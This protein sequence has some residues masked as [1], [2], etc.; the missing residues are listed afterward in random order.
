MENKDYVPGGCTALLDALGDTVKHIKNIHKYAR[1]EDVPE[2]TMFVI[3]TDG[4]EN[5]SK[6]YTSDQVKKEIERC[7][8]DGWEF[9]FL[10]ANIDAVE[11][12]GNIGISRERAVKY[13]CDSR[14]TKLNYSVLSRAISSVRE[15]SSINDNWKAEIEEDLANR[16]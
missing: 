9:L 14:G 11:V 10:G 16:K 12:A 15:C 5:A 4:A 3:I 2:H 1:K 8:E 7:K 6:K 13:K